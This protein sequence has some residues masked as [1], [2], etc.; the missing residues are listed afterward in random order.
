MGADLYESYW[1]N[2]FSAAAAL[3]AAAFL[4]QPASANA[5]LWCCPWPSRVWVSS[6]RLRGS[7]LCARGKGRISGSC[8]TRSPGG[9]NLSALL[10]IL[11]S[12]A[13]I[14]SMGLPNAWGLWG[15]VVVGLVVGILIGQ[16]T[17]YFTSAS[18]R[19]TREIARQAQTGPAYRDYRRYPL[20][21][22][23][24][25]SSPWSWSCWEP[26]SP[27]AWLRVLIL[28]RSVMVFTGSASPP[29]ACC[30]PWA[31]RSPA[32]L[33][34]PSPTTPVATP[35]CR[36]WDRSAQAHRRARRPRQHHGR[37]RQGLRPSVPRALTALALIAS[38]I[39]VI[40]M[41]M[42]A[43]GRDGTGRWDAC[44][45]KPCS[46]SSWLTF[47]SKLLNPTVPHG[48]V[49]GIRHSLHILRPY[50]ECRGHGGGGGGQPVEWL[51]KYGRQFREIPGILEGKAT[52]DYARCVWNFH[53][54]SANVKCFLPAGLAVGHSL[55]CRFGP[56]CARYNRS[57]CGALSRQAF[58]RGLP[59]QFRRGLG[60]CPPLKNTLKKVISAVKAPRR[61]KPLSSANTVGDPFKDTSG[62]SLNILIKLM[63]MVA[64]V[65]AGL[66]LVL[67][68]IVRPTF[69]FITC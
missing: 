7:S 31:S 17:E 47:E 60:Q 18:Y 61:T 9:I 53:C 25:R 34:D 5:R 10:I 15:A 11:G 44:G 22:C 55:V 48:C 8:S 51:T 49:F 67:T 52:P 33:T 41:A 56:G 29:S 30:P 23:S 6:F 62:P 2:P 68:A 3:G 38:Y 14:H 64:I 46:C 63:S 39:E 26:S 36:A 20:S 27:M 4:G 45:R 1:R 37:H 35:R 69:F 42:M 43:S 32:T 57:P 58:P 54:R 19:P 66:T 12:A 59:F 13:L 65:T 16:S 24:P 28:R 40:R 21:G 50:H